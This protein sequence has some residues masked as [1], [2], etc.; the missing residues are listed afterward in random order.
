MMQLVLCLLGSFQ[1]G[2]RCHLSW[3]G[4]G[5]I[6]WLAFD[7]RH[8]RLPLLSS[9]LFKGVRFAFVS[10]LRMTRGSKVCS[11]RS[12]FSTSLPQLSLTYWPTIKDARE[13]YYSGWQKSIQ[14]TGPQFWISK[15]GSIQMT[16][17]QVAE[18]WT[19]KLLLWRA[20]HPLWL[21]LSEPGH[22]LLWYS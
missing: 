7:F 10:A 13:Y 1:M 17:C 21:L 9:A 2:V 3:L 20:G 6:L 19:L 22:S 18:G 11:W 12:A 5:N 16:S 4:S 15:S 8:W 14:T